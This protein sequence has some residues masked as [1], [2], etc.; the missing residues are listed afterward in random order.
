M[1]AS[2]PPGAEIYVDGKFS[3]NTPSSLALAPGTHAL[4]VAAPHFKEWTRTL[5][6]RAGSQVNIR[7]VLEA[8]PRQISSA[9]RGIIR[10]QLLR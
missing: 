2:E 9:T 6:T 10:E 4:C 5:A 3:G 1:F 8:E 7:A